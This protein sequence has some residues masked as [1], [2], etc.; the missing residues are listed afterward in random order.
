MSSTEKLKVW[1]DRVLIVHFVAGVLYPAYMTFVVLR[2]EDNSVGPLMGRAATISL[3]LFI[4][5]R[6]YAIEFWLI[7]L[8]LIVYFAN[9]KRIF[10]WKD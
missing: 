1:I 8:L 5:R 7:S 6:L 4:R 3:D 2:P 9:R 10:G